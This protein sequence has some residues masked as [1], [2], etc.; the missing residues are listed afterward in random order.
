MSRLAVVELL[1]GAL[2]GAALIAALVND[3]LD[4]LNIRLRVA[5]AVA[6][7][8]FG[9]EMRKF[10]LPKS[11]GRRVTAHNFGYLIRIVISFIILFH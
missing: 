5:A 10:F 3:L 4:D 7:I 2:D 6:G 9:L 1:L 8:T 11:K